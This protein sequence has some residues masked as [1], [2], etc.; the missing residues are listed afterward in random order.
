M[1]SLI[2]SNYRGMGS[3]IVA[4]G[5]RL[6]PPESRRAVRARRR[7]TPTST[8]RASGRSTPSSPRFVTKD[9]KPSC[10]LRRHGRRHAAA[11]PRPDPRATSIDFGMNLQEAGDAAALAA[12]RLVRADRRTH[13]RRRPPRARERLP[14]PRSCAPLRAAATTSA[15]PSPSAFGGYQAIRATATASTTAPRRAA[16][17]ATRPGGDRLPTRRTGAPEGVDESRGRRGPLGPLLAREGTGPGQGDGRRRQGR[18]PEARDLVHARGHP[19]AACRS[20]TTGCRPCRA[21]TRCRT[22]TPRAKPTSSS[23]TPACRPRSCW[24]RS[25]GTTSSTSGSGPKKGPDGDYL[26]TLPIGQ[27]KLAGI[28]AEDIGACAYGVF[29]RGAALVGKID[30]PGRRA[31]DRRR[32]GRQD[33]RARSARPCATTRC[34]RRRT[35]ASASRAPTTSATCRHT[36]PPPGSASTV[37][38]ARGS[39]QCWSVARRGGDRAPARRNPP[40]KWHHRSFVRV[41]GMPIGRPCGARAASCSSSCWSSSR[42]SRS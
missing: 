41:R 40:W 16:R 31:P 23:R 42:S 11:G 39:G 38:L 29:K 22:S 34:R 12:R 18:R 27:A 19:H 32:D 28:A 4:A 24:R 1:V 14:G 21:S 15:P 37:A 13:D 8:R 30:R 36:R 33:E 10:S 5:P 2:Q 6:R 3:G 7:A 17:T 9:G 35:A 20:A 25:T 26:L